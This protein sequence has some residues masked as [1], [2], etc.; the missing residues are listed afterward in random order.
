MLVYLM[1]ACSIRAGVAPAWYRRLR[2]PLTAAVLAC[3]ALALAALFV[4]DAG[5]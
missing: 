2:I 1:D 5:T 4:R 3:L